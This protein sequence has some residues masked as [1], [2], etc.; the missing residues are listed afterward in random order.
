MLPPARATVQRAAQVVTVGETRD[1]EFT[2]D[3]P[4]ELR[5]SLVNLDRTVAALPV[6][7]Q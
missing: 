7:V 2:P 1:F 6:F 4:G 3:A 5:L